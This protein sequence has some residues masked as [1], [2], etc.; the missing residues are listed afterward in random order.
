[1]N[2]EYFYE[3]KQRVSVLDAAV[4]YGYSPNRAGFIC[5]PL[6]M[7]KTPSLKLYAGTGG[8]HC[9]GCQQ[10]GSVIDFV[11]QIFGLSLLEA[12]RKIIADFG[13]PLP[14]DRPLSYEES[15]RIKRRHYISDTFR[16]YQEWRKQML[17]FMNE[18]YR[19]G[20]QSLNVESIDDFSDSEIMAIKWMPAIEYWYSILND[21]DINQQMQVFRNRKEVE[22]LCFKILS[23]TSTKSDVA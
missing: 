12:V 8:W 3:V 13:L 23:N 20:W 10:G 4:Y 17:T 15:V 14:L 22:A 18:V 2:S 9:F 6:H 1:M 7:E 11:S 19:I 16:Q 21:T 5:C